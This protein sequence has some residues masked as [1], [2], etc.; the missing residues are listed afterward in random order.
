MS[1]LEQT[2]NPVDAAVEVSEGAKETK[3]E[4]IKQLVNEMKD[5]DKE[6]VQQFFNAISE[7]SVDETLTKS[8]IAR[9]IVESLKQL[10]EESV[11]E[12]FEAKVAKEEE[13]DEDDKEMDESKDEDDE[14][15]VEES[16]DEDQEDEVDESKEEDSD[17]EVEEGYKKKKMKEEDDESDSDD[18][19]DEDEDEME[20]S[21]NLDADLKAIT[22]SLELSE[23]SAQKAGTL[24]KAAVHSKVEEIKSQLEEQTQQ[25]LQ[26]SIDIIKDDL[27]EAVDK[28]LAYVAEEWT[29]ENELAIE[30]G[31]RSEMTENFIEGLKDLFTEHYVEVPE[32]KYDVVDELA[33]RLDEMELKLDGEVSKNMELSEELDSLK[34]KEV[35]REACNDLTESQIEKLESLAN[36]IDFK[37]EEDFAEKV[38][39][40]KEAYF[41]VSDETIAEE[42]IV[43]EGTGLFEET[44]QSQTKHVTP[45]MQKYLSAISKHQPL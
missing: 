14:E 33:N 10:D 19:D 17:D 1:E 23:E 42:T 6:S 22:E 36:G 35:V 25:E 31:L 38:S 39:E 21:F 43:E 7:E 45:E 2:Q 29:K 26:T 30:R 3:M 32:E 41:V 40:I 4:I 9:S 44:E 24:F 27:A 15:E 37:T 11:R 5:M 18:D 16:K 28:Y 8:E 20:E 13:E 12:I 34:R